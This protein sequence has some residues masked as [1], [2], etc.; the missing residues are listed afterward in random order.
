MI[1]AGVGVAT[2]TRALAGLSRRRI[3]RDFWLLLIVAA[4]TRLAVPQRPMHYYFGIANL[5][6]G[7]YWFT[8]GSSYFPLPNRLITFDLGFGF[9]GLV[10]LNL[11]L[12]I[13]TVLLLWL[14]ARWAG[15]GD[16]PATAFALLVATTPLY[17]RLSASDASNV[18]CLFLWA[19]AALSFAAVRQRRGGAAAHLALFA[20]TVA[21]FPIRLESAFGMPSAALLAAGGV[22]GYKEVLHDWR[23][24]LAF[25]IA[26][27]IGA[28]VALA[29]HTPTIAVP[30]TGLAT[31]TPA[32]LWGLPFRLS[33]FVSPVPPYFFPLFIPAAYLFHIA[34]RLRNRDW[35]AVASTL[36][37]VVFVSLPFLI[38]QEAIFVAMNEAAYNIIALM[39]YLMPA[40][41]GLLEIARRLRE[42]PPSTWKRVAMA[43]LAVPALWLFIF[44]PYRRTV[45]F[46]DELRFLQDHLPRERA[47]IAVIWDPWA[48]N[49]SD[50]WFSD[51]DQSLSLPYPPLL[52]DHTDLEWVILKAEDLE[53]GRLDTLTFD[54][55]YPGTLARLETEKVDPWSLQ[56]LFP[57]DQRVE[58]ERAHIR[59]LKRLDDEVRRRFVLLP[60]TSARIPMRHDLLM[61]RGTN[62]VSI[63]FPDEPDL[64]LTIYRR[65][66]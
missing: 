23:R 30:Q 3:P 14:T 26:L 20:A 27:V 31:I 62:S 41:Q 38:G 46:Q 49:K 50:I 10:A 22:A 42:R 43:I 35:L 59:I 48:T 54:Y 8:K 13:A 56:A 45:V 7:R 21:A 12:G 53:S 63:G 15:Y 16:K 9:D 58:T 17:V 55:Y 64:E 61:A 34:T 5:P 57:L 40:G 44:L 2:L 60:A 47:T 18:M 6:I 51:Y 29:Y 66:R 4:A 37:P 24:F 19:C 25:W 32:L 1:M 11:V 33:G 36:I 28:V 39:F 65:N 52:G